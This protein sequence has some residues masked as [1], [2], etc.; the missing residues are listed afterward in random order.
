MIFIPYE[1]NT[2]SLL[3]LNDA[4]SSLE[5]AVANLSTTELMVRSR[6][7]N[8][9]ERSFLKRLEKSEPAKRSL[10]I[11]WQNQKRIDY[12]IISLRFQ[13]MVEE[14]AKAIEPVRQAAQCVQT[15]IF[16]PEQE[17]NIISAEHDLAW[18]NYSY[19]LAL[20]SCAT[21][22]VNRYRTN[23]AADE[24]LST[25][26]DALRI[27]YKK[28]PGITLSHV[29]DMN[30][31]NEDEV[32]GCGQ[33][34]STCKVAPLTV[35]NP[36]FN[37]VIELVEKCRATQEQT[38][39]LIHTLIA[40]VKGSLNEKNYHTQLADAAAEPYRFDR[41]RRDQQVHRSN[42]SSFRIACRTSNAKLE[43]LLAEL[44]EAFKVVR[45]EPLPEAQ[46]DRD[47]LFAAGFIVYWLVATMYELQRKQAHV[48]WEDETQGAGKLDA[49]FADAMSEAETLANTDLRTRRSWY[50]D[51]WRR[52]H[53]FAY[54]Q[55][56]GADSLEPLNK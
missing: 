8:V 35:E 13:W 25:S 28:L 56:F 54:L 10:V 43:A 34:F 42:Y 36:A 45:D 52:A 38:A 47:R 15:A 2:A 30:L 12:A 49:L 22:L 17:R 19:A 4:V 51:A 20:A 24:L 40:V 26:L 32:P 7:Y 44:C 31:K 33:F 37:R 18:N 46:V 29:I 23:F 16:Q 55:N 21:E 48:I 41:L 1:G 39:K 27:N 11:R 3:Q 14:A 53:A 9:E 5:S 50:S 6:G